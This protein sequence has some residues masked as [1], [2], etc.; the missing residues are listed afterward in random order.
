MREAHRILTGLV[1]E[2]DEVHTS[3]LE[4]LVY[5][6]DRKA[7]TTHGYQ[8]TTIQYTKQYRGP[9]SK[10]I[11]DAINDLLEEDVLREVDNKKYKID[12]HSKAREIYSSSKSESKDAISVVVKTHRDSDPKSILEH[13]NSYPQVESTTKYG[14][15]DFDGS[16]QY[17][18]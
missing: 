11:K 15:I 9:S 17:T 16:N 18:L 8:V 14:I 3:V 7:I 12:Y 2:F 10:V 13:I 4:Q 6:T 1:L 5:E